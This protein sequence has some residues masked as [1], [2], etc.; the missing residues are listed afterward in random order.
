[1]ADAISS[2]D[3]VIAIVFVP[4]E[5]ITCGPADI[6]AS[7]LSGNRFMPKQHKTALIIACKTRDMTSFAKLSCVPEMAST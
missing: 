5:S 7:A 3:N 4:S 6:V 2:I 1:M